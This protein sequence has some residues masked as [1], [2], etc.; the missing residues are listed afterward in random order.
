MLT[1]EQAG[2]EHIMLHLIP[3]KPAAIRK[4]EEALRVYR[5]LSNEQGK[6]ANLIGIDSHQ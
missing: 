1:Y 4:L 5:Q 3:Y 6:K 2:V